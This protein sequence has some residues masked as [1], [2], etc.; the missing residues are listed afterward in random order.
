MSLQQVAAT[1]SLCVYRLRDKLLQQVARHFARAT[2]RFLCS[3]NRVLSLQEV[4]Q[5]QSD[6]ILCDLILLRRQ[7]F[8]QKNSSAHTKR[9]VAVTCRRNVLLQLVAWCVSP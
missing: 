5:I 7:R 8:S 6:L 4:A 1:N 9:L 2:S 3:S